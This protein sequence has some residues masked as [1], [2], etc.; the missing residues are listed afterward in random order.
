MIGQLHILGCN[1]ALPTLERNATSQFLQLPSHS[2]LIDAGECSIK[3]AMR[4]KTKINRSEIICISHLHGDHYFGLFGL[5]TTWNLNGRTEPL[6]IICPKALPDIL[7]GILG[8]ANTILSYPLNLIPL[9][10]SSQGVVFQEHELSISVQMVDHRID[11]FAY[12][13][14]WTSERANF[15]KE[16][17]DNLGIELNHEIIQRIV[18]KED[19]E[20]SINNT[21]YSASDFRHPPKHY[22]YTYITDTAYL[23]NIHEFIRGSNLLYHEATYPKGLE[24]HAASRKHS[25]S[26]EAYQVAK[27]SGVP[28]L[29]IGHYSAKYS[30]SELELFKE[31]LPIQEGI[32]CILSQDGLTIE[33]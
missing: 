28:I 27:D 11:C 17:M 6:T 12:R 8:A 20:F 5:L 18:L 26:G 7:A 14:N 2:I 25:T 4:F 24:V 15:N 33:F 23:P 22:C 31:G 10:S 9:D 13:F 32:E 30:N 19:F 1:S 16:R 29:I 3:Q 21:V